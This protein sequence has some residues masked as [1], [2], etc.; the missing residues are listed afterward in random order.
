MHLASFT[1]FTQSQNRKTQ[2]FYIETLGQLSTLFL[3][4]FSL[5]C[6]IVSPWLSFGL[7]LM[8]LAQ[9]SNV[10]HCFYCYINLK[11]EKI[12]RFIKRLSVNGGSYEVLNDNTQSLIQ[13]QSTDLFCILIIF[14]LP[15]SINLQ[16]LICT[17]L[18][19]LKEK[20]HTDRP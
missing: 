11:K 16:V 4:C 9:L 6:C 7:L 19:I 15:N 12:K 20:G 17:S 1:V 5:S 13:P 10:N 2:S 8:I 3:L 14:F 18:K